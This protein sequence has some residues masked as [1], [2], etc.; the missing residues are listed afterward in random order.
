MDRADNPTRAIVSVLMLREGWDV[1][2]VTVIV[3]IRA[4]TAKAG[5]LPEQAVGRGVRLM[6]PLG[7]QSGWDEQVDIIGTPGFEAFMLQLEGEGVAFGAL[8]VKT[9][10]KI[11]TIAPLDDRRETLD[12]QLPRLT[13]ALYK[14]ADQL[15]SM[16]L[17]DIPVR[18]IDPGSYTDN[19]VQE[20]RRIDAI[21]RQEKDRSKLKIPYPTVPQE[22]IAYWTDQ[23]RLKVRFPGR[24][25]VI[26][27]LVQQY[28]AGVLFGGP[29]DWQKRTLLRR[30]LDPDVGQT[31][32]DAFVEAIN[33]HTIVAQDAESENAPL[34][35]ADTDPFP[36][37]GKTYPGTKTVFN[38]VACDNDFERQ[39]AEFFDTVPDV[40]AY[41]KIVTQMRFSIE[42]VSAT[43]KLRFYRPDYVVRAAD[44][45][46][47]VETKGR[48]DADVARK[49]ARAA[50]WCADATRLTNTP[51]QY[52]K[53]PQDIFLHTSATSFLALAKHARVVTNPVTL[54][55]LPL[56]EN[57]APTDTVIGTA[58]VTSDAPSDALVAE[59]GAS[60]TDA[61][62]VAVAPPRFDPSQ[63]VPIAQLE[64]LKTEMTG[65]MQTM[66]AQIEAL[67]RR[68]V[69]PQVEPMEARV[70]AAEV[71]AWE[72]TE[73]ALKPVWT[74][75]GDESRKE[76]V[77]ATFLLTTPPPLL[78]GVIR[79]NAAGEAV[80]AIARAFERELHRH[81]TGPLVAKLGGE[82]SLVA[83]GKL[84]SLPRNSPP[85]L[86]ET[87]R[88]LAL[89]GD[90]PPARAFLER[91]FFHHTDL[92]KH[93]PVFI[94][95]L[96]PVRNRAAHGSS[97]PVSRGEAELLW[98]LAM[99]KKPGEMPSPFLPMLS[100]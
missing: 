30:L 73:A 57:E 79:D 13:P 14:S 51:W 85:S 28:V 90:L 18:V 89:C 34:S 63:F 98:Q 100:D 48:E 8:D 11:T 19:E 4:M 20:Y 80:V 60:V 43:G 12:V 58:P 5:I 76:L 68:E 10:P 41:T 93:L 77:R 95:Q 29:T 31:L 2:N 64:S 36:W 40:A 81:V 55:S 47:L 82:R 92:W 50:Q 9:K 54:A 7:P 42:Y 45:M 62:A 38:L 78:P 59:A 84:V 3:G 37:S 44:G 26:A 74:L 52:L 86:D 87:E 21:T 53:I 91:R 66:M 27:P 70:Q 97:T 83:N 46:Y 88:L 61:P 33:R 39:V 65:M 22:I 32:V 75:L 71:R 49:D 17:A 94:A 72:D 24:F 15:A 35:V 23:I 1:K 67:M 16:T 25:N 6:S 99:D 69:A 56:P 96:R